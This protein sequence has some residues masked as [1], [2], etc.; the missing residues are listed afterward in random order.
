L[1]LS[2]IHGQ[3]TTQLEL[4]KETDGDFLGHDLGHETRAETKERP[5][6]ARASAR[7]VHEGRRE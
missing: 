3:R 5:W 7:A 4:P 6:V 2:Y 1:Q